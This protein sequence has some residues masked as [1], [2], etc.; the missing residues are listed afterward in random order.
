[1]KTLNVV[2]ING[3]LHEITGAVRWTWKAHLEIY[4]TE[5]EPAEPIMVFAAGKWISFTRGN[6][7]QA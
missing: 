5:L 3:Q 7:A 2:D 4:N 6:H 1:M